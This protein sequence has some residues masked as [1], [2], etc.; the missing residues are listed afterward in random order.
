MKRVFV[1]RINNSIHVEAIIKN[2]GKSIEQYKARLFIIESILSLHRAEFPRRETLAER[3]QRLNVMLH[4]LTRVAEIY[5]VAA[6]DLQTKFSRN[7]IILSAT[8]MIQL[9][10]PTEISWTMLA[11]TGFSLEKQAV[12]E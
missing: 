10:L 3:Q 6:V 9:G 4:K 7:Q 8:G 5:N 11:H 12:R 1:S 2:L